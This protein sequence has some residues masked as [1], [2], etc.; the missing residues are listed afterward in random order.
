MNYPKKPG[1]NLYS[2]HH[3]SFQGGTTVLPALRS[4]CIY[5]AVGIIV[6]YVLQVLPCI[7]H[8]MCHINYAIHISVPNI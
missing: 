8:E 7:L 1:V 2:W 5:C 6:V 3:I 4:F